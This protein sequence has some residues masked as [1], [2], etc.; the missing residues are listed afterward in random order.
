[1]RI[2]WPLALLLLIAGPARADWSPDAAV[3]EAL[4]RG[5]VHAEVNP[6]GGGVSGVVHGAVEIDASPETVWATILDCRRAGRMARSVKT[7]RLTG[8]DPRGRWDEREMTVRWNSLMPT[9]RTV[10]RSEFEPLGR[11]TFRCIGGDIRYC[12][13]EWRLQPLAG[14]RT[15]VIYENRASSPIPAPAFIARAAMRQDVADA[16]RALRREAEMAER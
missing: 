16:L 14:G 13:G 12:K 9:F 2:G 15:R 1:M 4:A 3:L 7:C 11:I 10:F 8:R 6:D 5:S